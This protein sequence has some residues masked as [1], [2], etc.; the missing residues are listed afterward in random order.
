MGTKRTL[1]ILTGLQFS[2]N[3]VQVQSVA[4]MSIHN[5]S[6]HQMISVTYQPT[7]FRNRLKELNII[8]YHDHTVSPLFPPELNIYTLK[9]WTLLSK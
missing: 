1:H 7:C 8:V 2:R 5:N 9:K 3:L 4:K 6:L